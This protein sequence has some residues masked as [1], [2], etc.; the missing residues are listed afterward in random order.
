VVIS[1]LIPA[2]EGMLLEARDDET[3]LDRLLQAVQA[4][5]TQP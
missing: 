5:A 3:V 4:G 2:V 1:D